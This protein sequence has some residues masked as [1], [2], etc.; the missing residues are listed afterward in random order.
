MAP[1]GGQQHGPCRKQPVVGVTEKYGKSYFQARARAGW[2]HYSLDRN[3][4]SVL[5]R[6]LRRAVWAAWSPCMFAVLLLTACTG[7]NENG[8]HVVP[9]DGLFKKD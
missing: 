3:P 1:E 9:V 2:A 7:L 5:S 8:P 6:C 4:V